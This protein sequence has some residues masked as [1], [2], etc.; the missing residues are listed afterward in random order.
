[1]EQPIHTYEIKA[2]IDEAVSRCMSN[3]PNCTVLVAKFGGYEIEKCSFKNADMQRLFR[4]ETEVN[5]H[6][7][8]NKTGYSLC[9]KAQ[10]RMLRTL[11]AVSMAR[12]TA[13]NRTGRIRLRVIQISAVMNTRYVIGEK[14]LS[15]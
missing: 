10:H 9:E 6:A 8:K 4:V 1:M 15:H 2:H 12:G 13:W 3:G 5:D 14:A 11:L 7:V